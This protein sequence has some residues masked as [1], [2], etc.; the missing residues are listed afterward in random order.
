MKSK[1]R[2]ISEAADARKEAIR[3]NAHRRNPDLGNSQDGET[4]G[5]G[6]TSAANREPRAAE[7][8]NGMERAMGAHADKL[9]PTNR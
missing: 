3:H 2:K 4:T 7:D 1:S 5:R 8:Q 6:G 9:H